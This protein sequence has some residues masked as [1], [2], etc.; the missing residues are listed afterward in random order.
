MGLDTETAFSVIQRSLEAFDTD[1]G[2]ARSAHAESEQTLASVEYE[3]EQLKKLIGENA[4]PADS[5]S[6]APMG[7]AVE[8]T[9]QDVGGALLRRLVRAA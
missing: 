2:R 6:A 5:P 3:F 8:V 9:G 4:L 7:L 1:V